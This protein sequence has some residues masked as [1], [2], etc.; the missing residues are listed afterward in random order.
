MEFPVYKRQSPELEPYLQL[1]AQ[2]R[3]WQKLSAQLKRHLP[4][5][6][7]PYYRV[8]C[9]EDDALV[10]VAENSMVANRLKMLA[11]ALLDTWEERPPSVRRVKVSLTP[12]N[13]PPPR[14]N[15][16]SLHDDARAALT[17]SAERLKHH[18]ELAAILHDLAKI[19]D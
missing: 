14:R 12:H 19:N 3:L 11:P 8:T 16:L 18:P 4:A 5:N 10:I 6:L 1:V 2:Y 13:M 17:R 9:I 7:A 15:A